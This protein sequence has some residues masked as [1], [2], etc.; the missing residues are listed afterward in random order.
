MR[1]YEGGLP[2]RSTRQDQVARAVAI[3]KGYEARADSARR[4]R[5][6]FSFERMSA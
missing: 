4:E 6:F 5:S 2:R 3:D 1:L